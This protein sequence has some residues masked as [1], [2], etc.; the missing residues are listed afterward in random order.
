MLK[1]QATKEKK[2]LDFITEFKTF[3]HYDSMKKA[4]RQCM[5]WE[6]IFAINTSDKGSS[7]Q[8]YKRL[9]YLNNKKTNT[10]LKMWE[11]I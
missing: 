6:K 1:G 5:E 8:I 7:I 11:K 2:K 4:K 10:V 3:V 9:F